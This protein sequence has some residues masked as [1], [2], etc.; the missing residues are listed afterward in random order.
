MLDYTIHDADSAPDQSREILAAARA[1]YGFLP[2]LLAI[3]AE[4]PAALKGYR[5]LMTTFGNSSLTAAEQQV[6]LLSV[7][8]ENE[9][10]YCVSAHTALAHKVKVPADVVEAIRAR[11]PI[12]DGRLEALRSLARDI[13][14]SRGRPADA[15]VNAFLAA[16]YTKGQLLEVVLGVGVKT[17]SNYV[18]H[19]VETPIDVPFQQTLWPDPART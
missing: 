15:V 7:S 1:A 2:N 11:T 19:L 13:V 16:G 5:D 17:I 6:V 8:R 14:V 9:C 10:S 3:L 18:N 12:A 4:S